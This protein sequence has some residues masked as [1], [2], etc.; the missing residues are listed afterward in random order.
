MSKVEI[1]FKF[2]VGDVVTTRLGREENADRMF[3]RLKPRGIISVRHYEECPGGFQLHYHVRWFTQDG[4]VME[5]SFIHHEHELLPA[6]NFPEVSPDDRARSRL[7]ALAA[8]KPAE[9]PD[10]E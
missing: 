1:E 9:K 3:A 4:N 2:N 7:G 10:G 6:E 5:R 8:E